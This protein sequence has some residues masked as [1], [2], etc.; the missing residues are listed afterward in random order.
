MKKKKH[1]ILFLLT[2][3]TFF[4]LSTIFTYSLFLVVFCTSSFVVAI[5]ASILF[6]KPSMSSSSKLDLVGEV[7]ESDND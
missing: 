6:R 3:N 7:I 2:A 5:A 1:L 4:C